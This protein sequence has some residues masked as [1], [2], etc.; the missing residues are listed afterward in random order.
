MQS[1]IQRG[2]STSAANSTCQL[3]TTMLAEPNSPWEFYSV[4]RLDPQTR[5]R[6]RVAQTINPDAK[7]DIFEI[8]PEV[9][10]LDNEVVIRKLAPSAFWGTP[11]VSF[12]R[13]EHVDT[14]LVCGESTS[15]C[16]RATVMDGR[17]TASTR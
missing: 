14:L 6:E 7:G 5:T 16:V 9:A 3:S 12:L 17:L 15:G 11:L 10:P 8:V 2:F 4:L 1:N 13:S